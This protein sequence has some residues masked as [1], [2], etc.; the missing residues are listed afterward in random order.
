MEIYKHIRDV[1]V[2]YRQSCS[3]MEQERKSFKKRRNFPLWKKYEIVSRFNSGKIKNVSQ[4]AK[5]YEIPRSS[6]QTIL[7]NKN[8]VI[9]E[10]EAGRNA[11]MKKKRKHNFDN[12]D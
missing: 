10:F 9:S 1:L 11:E 12:V 7:S 5:E 2:E 4:L 6:L 8:K 3:E